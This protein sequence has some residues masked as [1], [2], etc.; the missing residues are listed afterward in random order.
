[1]RRKDREIQGIDGVFDVVD[2]CTVVH[3]SMVDG[4]KPYGVALNFGYDRDGDDLVL[5]FHS[6]AEGRKMDILRQNPTVYFQMHCVDEF[7]YA[8]E[9]VTDSVREG[10]IPDIPCRF[11]WRFD[12]AAGSGEV[13]FVEDDAEK[14]HALNRIIR[15]LTKKDVTYEFPRIKL[16]KTCVYKVRS[17]DITG[18]HHE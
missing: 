14:A 18:K 10:H 5:Y 7:I 3:L 11:C 8:G 17:S 2:R 13:E 1:M 16:D 9:P 15:N 6:A 12:S 4:G